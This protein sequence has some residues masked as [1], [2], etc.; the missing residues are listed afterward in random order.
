MKSP[1]LFLLMYL[2]NVLVLL[3]C[4]GSIYSYM[5]IARYLASLLSES[6]ELE[7]VSEFSRL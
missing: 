2:K 5:N 4:G 6:L 7:P 3:M 1:D